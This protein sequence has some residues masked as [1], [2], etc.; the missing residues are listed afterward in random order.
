MIPYFE[1]LGWIGAL[2]ILIAYYLISQ[3][4]V[5]A[6][7]KLYQ[8]LNLFGAFGVGMNVFHQEA[9]SSFVLQIIWAAIALRALYTIYKK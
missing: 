3:Q 6:A 1:I 5:T 7:S 4:K 2:L 9:Y 8:L